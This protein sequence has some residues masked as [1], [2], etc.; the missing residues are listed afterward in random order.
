MMVVI[1]TAQTLFSLLAR[2]RDAIIGEDSSISYLM[3]LNS[4]VMAATYSG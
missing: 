1:L 4:D 2:A 3:A